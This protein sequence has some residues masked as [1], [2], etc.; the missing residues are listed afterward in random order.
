[1]ALTTLNTG[2]IALAEDGVVLVD[3]V[4]LFCDE[5]L[6]A[7]GVGSGVGHGQAR[8]VEVQTRLNSSMNM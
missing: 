7:V 3:E 6:A 4:G 2:V 1:M 8:A 5:E